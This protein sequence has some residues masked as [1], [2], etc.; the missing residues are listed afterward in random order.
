MSDFQANGKTIKTSPD[1]FLEDPNDWDECVME[2]LITQYE[3]EG[4]PEVG[5]LGRWLIKFMRDYYEEHMVHPSLN[6]ILRLWDKLEGHK[7][8]SRDAFRDTLFEMFPRG[9]IPALTR[10]AGLPEQA[11]EE[12]FDAG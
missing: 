3:S 6:R 12:E 2:A 4:N 5:A 1:G 10:M 11:V 9:P 8:E 7:H